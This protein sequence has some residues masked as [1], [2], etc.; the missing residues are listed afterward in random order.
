MG[1]SRISKSLFGINRDRWF[2]QG[3]RIKIVAQTSQSAGFPPEPRSSRRKEAPSELREDDQ[4]LLTSAATVQGFYARKFREILSL[5]V[6]VT[7][8]SRATFQS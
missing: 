3:D 2:R 4:S 7:H 6:V 1:V 5:L 8:F